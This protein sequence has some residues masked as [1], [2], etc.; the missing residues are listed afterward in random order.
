[1]PCRVTSIV[2]GTLLL[3]GLTAQ[4]VLANPWAHGGRSRGGGT[5][6][7]GH[8]STMGEVGHGS[9]DQPS[10]GG[11]IETSAGSG[12]WEPE[13]E[14]LQCG[15][16]VASE[17]DAANSG[18]TPGEGQAVGVV[19]CSSQ[20]PTFT[21]IPDPD[22][23][24][25][26]A[27]PVV[28]PVVLMQVA[29]N[30][31]ALPEPAVA[32]NP[33]PPDEQIVQVPSWLWIDPAQWRAASASASAGAVTATVTAVPQR[34]VWDMGNGDGVVCDGPG[35][36]Y[37]RRFADTPEATDCKYTYRQSSAGVGPRD[38]Y[39]VTATVQWRLSWS[40]T[41]APGGGDLGTVAMTTTTEL[42]VAELQALTR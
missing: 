1:M 35:R 32:F 33:A 25:D 4:A 31:L 20:L 41:G 28:D 18:L 11:G 5:V 9:A 3:V 15:L 37:E 6:E 30:R 7:V 2:V 40:A 16:A 23:E 13:P 36:A 42:Q 10:S 34:V 29:R 17:V 38:A 26:P 22:A 27:V 8:T 39:T 14:T 19:T 12:S 24:G 21:L